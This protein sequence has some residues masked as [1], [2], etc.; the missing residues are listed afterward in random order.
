M[1]RTLIT[2]SLVQF[3][4][5]DEISAQY[6]T[7]SIGRAAGWEWFESMATHQHT[8]GF[9]GATPPATTT[10]LQAGG[11]LEIAGAVAHSLNVGD[12]FSITGVYNVNP[13]TRRKTATLKQFKVLSALPSGTGTRTVNI[14]PPIIGPPSPYQNVDQLPAAGAALIL[15]PGTQFQ[16]TAPRQG[17]LGI[18]LNKLFAAMAGIE[19]MMP[20]E[21]GVVN[22]ARQRR[23]PN[24]GISIAIISMFDGILRR[25]I[26]RID[27]LIGFGQL[28]HDR[29][30]VLV[31]SSE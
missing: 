18:G 20:A 21:G 28:Y 5:T 6:K 27:A 22:L 11:T 19:L 31:A 26:N 14:Q 8:T 13:R 7:G 29:C 17:V 16:G 12:I 30:G 1:M 15:W 9:F 10:A 25:Q 24:T 4:P 23:D 3:N 2:N